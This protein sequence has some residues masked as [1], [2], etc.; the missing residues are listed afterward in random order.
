[1]TKLTPRAAIVKQFHAGQMVNVIDP[2]WVEILGASVVEVVG[3]VS[4]SK[5]PGSR[6]FVKS[7]NTVEAGLP[8]SAYLLQAF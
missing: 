3:V 6:W 4:K 2:S 1:M 5:Q 7:P 8:L